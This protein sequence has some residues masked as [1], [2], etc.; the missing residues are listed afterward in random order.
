[1]LCCVKINY[2]DCVVLAVRV[3]FSFIVPMHSGLYKL[4]LPVK[5]EHLNWPALQ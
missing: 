4:Q 2:E 3:L 1:M 5:C